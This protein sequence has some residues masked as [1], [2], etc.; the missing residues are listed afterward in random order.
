MTIWK[1]S[2]PNSSRARDIEVGIELGDGPG[3]AAVHASDLSHDYVSL[4]ADYRS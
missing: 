4:N 3:V 1:N 2:L